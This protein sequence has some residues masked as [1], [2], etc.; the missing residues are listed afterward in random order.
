MPMVCDTA[1]FVTNTLVNGGSVL[2]EGANAHLLD[3][4]FGF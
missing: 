3:I 1:L 2:V 4:D